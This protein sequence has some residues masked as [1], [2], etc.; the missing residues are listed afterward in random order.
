MS[1][2]NSAKNAYIWRSLPIVF[3]VTIF[4]FLIRG[5]AVENGLAGFFWY[6]GN[7][8]SGDIYAYFRM[9]VFLVL[10]AVSIVYLIFTALSGDIKI[11]KHK[12]YIPMVIYG[13]FVL[14]SYLLA[15]YSHIALVGFDE[16]YEGT[17]VL[18]GYMCMVFYAMNMID[19]ERS[20]KIIF[21][22]FMIACVILGFWGVMQ[23]F[24]RDLD[25]LPQWLYVPASLRDAA[26]L[27]AKRAESAV[28]WFFSNQN[29]SS[30]FMI[31][32]ICTAGM[33]CIN[34]KKMYQKI[35]FAAIECLMLYSL[36]NAGSLGGMV[37]LAVSGVAALITFNK[38]IIKW[39]KSVVLLVIALAISM[40]V[41]LP[42]ITRELGVAVSDSILSRVV[43]A[44]EATEGLVY[45]DID[46]IVNDG[47]NI[48]F[49]FA[50]NEVTI[51]TAND[52]V[53]G[54]YD[55]NG[56]EIGTETEYMRVTETELETGYAGV[57]VETANR[58][59]AF[60]I[61]EGE[62][63]YISQSGQGVKLRKIDS[64]GFKNSQSFAT[65]RGYIWSRTLPLLKDTILVGHGADTFAIYFPQDDYAGRYNIGYYTDSASIMVDKPHN[66]YLGTAVNTGVI[67]LIALLAVFAM[68]LWESF[69]IYR[70]A[71][72]TDFVQFMGAGIF[73]AVCGFLVSGL[74][75]DSTIQVSPVFYALLG[76][77]FAIN[78]MLKKENKKN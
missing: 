30:F 43:Y 67:S 77:G 16:R 19:D 26:S 35:I 65:Y 46:Y 42:K 53:S 12:V 55:A 34:A 41:S 33:L 27:S 6:S 47:P 62:T 66:M 24:G 7:G 23:V 36:W 72:Y 9:Q 75:N 4:L 31:F 49:S 29:Y 20:L 10:T 14:L 37:G 38:K 28:R 52:K 17:F 44:D 18:I 25:V 61:V 58:H 50:G 71:E 70:K 48:I 57:T 74:V 76:V 78:K 51:T 2:R 60:G 5:R 32:P 40:G 56:N 59:W 3:L 1:G 22:G 8:Y 15:D 54:V 63:Y 73:V 13:L 45:A 64:L 39:A 21:Y 11:Y 69:K 68:Y